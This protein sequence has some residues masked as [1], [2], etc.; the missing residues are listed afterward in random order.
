MGGTYVAIVGWL[1]GM[2][3]QRD[4]SHSYWFGLVGVGGAGLCEWGCLG[5][6]VGRGPLGWSGSRSGLRLLLTPGIYC[7]VSLGI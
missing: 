2:R 4:H 7:L 5:L 3:A 1:V 6:V